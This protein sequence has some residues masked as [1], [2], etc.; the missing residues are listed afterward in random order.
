[1]KFYRRLQPI[2]AL[3]FDLDDTLY[4]NRPI[5]LNAE[6]KMLAYFSEHFPQTAAQGEQACR[7][8]WRGFRRQALHEQPQLVH[9][10]TALRL[11][12]Y[13]LAIKALGYTNSQAQSKAQAAFK[14]FTHHR[15][16]FTLPKASQHL[17]E[18]LAVKFP[19]IAITNG[20]V[21]FEK[22]GLTSLFQ[23]IY[24]PGNGIKRKPDNAMFN[25]ACQQ[26]QIKP[27]QLLH[28]GDCGSSDILGAL[29][30]GCQAAWLNRYTVGKPISVLPQIELST[31]DNLLFLL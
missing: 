13:T 16:D 9:D 24:N 31:L 18:K 14:H 8:Y 21:N 1:M 3:S 7:Q 10:V 12:N 29:Q 25:R 15:S 6:N 5:M 28:V 19:L 22:L 27:I 11:H 30:A 26:L 4:S 2:T 20:N 23:Y 17:L